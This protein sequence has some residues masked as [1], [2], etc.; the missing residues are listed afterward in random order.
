MAM[1]ISVGDTVGA[2]VKPADTKAYWAYVIGKVIA[3]DKVYHIEA[4][5]QQWVCS[6]RNIEK[7]VKV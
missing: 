4:N 3:I 2:Y 6:L 7:K 5:G 1:D